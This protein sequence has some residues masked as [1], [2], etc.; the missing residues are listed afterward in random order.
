MMDGVSMN[1]TLPESIDPLCNYL[2]GDDPSMNAFV[3]A[4]DKDI[5]NTY[6][7]STRYNLSDYKSGKAVNGIL[8]TAL[9]N[10]KLAKTC[11]EPGR[12]SDFYE[13][14]L[15]LME[16]DLK[17]DKFDAAS[18]HINLTNLM[19]ILNRVSLTNEKEP[20]PDS[21]YFDSPA[22]VN[23]LRKFFGFRSASIKRIMAVGIG[24]ILLFVFLIAFALQLCFGAGTLY[25][26]WKQSAWARLNTGFFRWCAFNAGNF[27]TKIG[28]IVTAENAVSSKV[29]AIT[30]CIIAVVVFIV[31]IV[32]LI[33]Q[34]K[35]LH[36]ELEIHYL[37]RLIGANSEKLRKEGW[38]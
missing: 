28:W 32:L 31:A 22:I 29:K 23:Q 21:P 35:R 37:C 10:K 12:L 2:F 6:S 25:A 3:E 27:L 36:T 14:T 38:L 8:N 17:S 20:D 33:M 19:A 16:E 15:S 13:K 18:A 9:T 7:K 24:W 4:L 26:T 30:A 1:I 11:S 34:I 5:L